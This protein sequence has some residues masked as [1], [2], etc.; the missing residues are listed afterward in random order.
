MSWT[1]SVT[2]TNDYTFAVTTG[3]DWTYSVAENTSVDPIRGLA[4]KSHT[5][6]TTKDGESILKV[7]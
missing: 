4:T 5:F 1:F 2:T 6:L 3:N 7:K